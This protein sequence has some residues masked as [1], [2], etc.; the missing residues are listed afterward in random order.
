MSTTPSHPK[1][2]STLHDLVRQHGVAQCLQLPCLINK[3]QQTNDALDA[4]NNIMSMKA[5]SLLNDEQQS[6]LLH[7]LIWHKIHKT[8]LLRVDPGL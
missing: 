4:F 3:P 6:R 7:N 8:R 1:F 5:F 2:I